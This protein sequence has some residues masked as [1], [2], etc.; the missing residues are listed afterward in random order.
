MRT[1]GG[2]CEE[3]MEQNGCTLVHTVYFI[4]EQQKQKL[5]NII[6]IKTPTTHPHTQTC[7]ISAG[8]PLFH[9]LASALLL[10]CALCN[11]TALFH[12]AI[13]TLPGDFPDNAAH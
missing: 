12:P 13:N 5:C 4:V 6:P 11:V 2:L 8:Y 10:D 3:G 9:V 1:R 7:R